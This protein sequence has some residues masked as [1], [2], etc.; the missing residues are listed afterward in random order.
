MCADLMDQTIFTLGNI[1]FIL[2]DIQIV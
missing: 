1:L 2:Q